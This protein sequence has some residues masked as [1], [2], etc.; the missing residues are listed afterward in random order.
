MKKRSLSLLLALLMV[1]SLV[2]PGTAAFA[3]TVSAETPA[4]ASDTELKWANKLGT[5]WMN[6]PSVPTVADDGVIVMVGTT[7]NKLGFENGEIIASGNMSSSPSYGYTPA[8]VNGD[9][10]IAPL[11]KGTLEA[12]DAKTLESKWRVSDELAGQALSPV[13]CA[14]GKAY[15]GFWNGEAK[16]ANFVC[17]DTATGELLWS[18]TV[19]GGFYWAGAAEVGSYVVVATDDGENGTK[20]TSSLLVFKKTYAENEEVKPVSSVEL[21][22]CGDAR[23]SITVDGG[24]VYFTT[25]GGYLCS[26]SVNAESGAISDLKTVSFNA[27][28]TSTPVVFG[29][30]VYFGA[31]SGISD[32]GS[33]G[34][35][36]IA[37]KNTLEVVNHVDML[38][39]PQCEMLLSTAYLKSTGYL[40]FYSTYNMD[41][42]GVS[43]IKV[44]ADDVSKTELTELYDAKGYEQYCIASLVAD[45]NGNLYYKNDSGNIFCLSTR[46]SEDVL[47]SIADKGS[48][49]LSYAAVNAY[50][51]N[52][53][54]SIDIDEVMYATHE[55]YYEGGAAAG[56]ASATGDYGA[57]ITKLWGD[58]SGNFGYF[59]D[60]KMTM[61]LGDKVGRGQH[62]YAYINANSYPNNDA[63]SYFETPA[64][65]C[66]TYAAAPVKLIAQNGYDEN[67]SPK[68]E[69]YDKAQLKAYTADL[70]TEAEGFKAVSKGNGEYSISF[71]KAGDYCVAATA[72]NNAI[73]PA[74]CKISVRAAN[75]FADVKETDYYYEATLWGSANNIVRGFSADEF[76]PN[77]PCTRAQIV[78]FLY[79]LAG[80]PEVSGSCKFADV[81]DKNYI[82]AI[83]WA[84]EEGVTKGTTETTFSPNAT[85]TRAQAVTFL[86]RYMDTPKADQAH[87]FTDV[88]NTGAFYYD[89][90]MWAAD[91]GVTLGFA[92]G[93]FRPG[94]VCT[95][96]EIV[97]FIYRA[98]A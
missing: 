8:V 22:G 78:T 98:A 14:D 40:Y 39:Y 86:H 36:V 64:F 87:G 24:K 28:S 69:G 82:D 67:W 49:E 57:Y 53:D 26:A 65:D 83:T 80:S 35:F 18:Y 44:K 47:V 79:R 31:G 5:D 58:E 3:D 89:A 95:R 93:S 37:D 61:G 97:T 30:Y 29:N 25:K 85:C 23:S 60:D 90:V 16:D 20:G 55:Q 62:V 38:G 50:D 91:N 48:V 77:V 4:D 88:T 21:A 41:P 15:T 1:L 96:G 75:G 71:A 73:I 27:Q 12:F 72:E 42:G 94:A 32:S 11:G 74:V 59:V 70:K 84:A 52:N 45:D 92:D 9:K 63:Y 46:T 6:A 56:Y 10:I 17:V 43:L 76:A 51:R 2:M 13:L 34:S 54:G 66:E 68:F 33:K 7:I 19:K 81:T